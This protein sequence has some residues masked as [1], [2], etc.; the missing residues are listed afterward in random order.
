MIA[1]N[2]YK[3]Y[4]SIY[5]YLE[6]FLVALSLSLSERSGLVTGIYINKQRLD[7]HKL[8]QRYH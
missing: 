4:A 7:K 3:L 1:E 6:V 2:V 8:R 5:D